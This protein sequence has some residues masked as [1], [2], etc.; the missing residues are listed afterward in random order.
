[1][2]R[3]IK[4][5]ILGG[6]M[7]AVTAVVPSL[8]TVAD[9][10]GITVYKDGDKYVKMGGRIQIQYHYED[11]DTGSPTDRSV[12]ELFFR[13]LRP[14]IEGSLHKDWKGK[15]QFDLGKSSNDNE[16]VIK[17]AYMQYTGIENVKVTVGNSHTP[18]SR[19][20]LTSSKKQQLVERTFVGDHNYGSPDRNLGIHVKGTTSDKKIGWAVSAA[21]ASIDPDDDKLDFDTPVNKSDDWNEGWLAGARLDFHPLGHLAMAQGDFKRDETKATISVAAFSWNNDDDNNT[22]TDATTGL[23]DGKGKPDVDTVTGYEISGALRTA[24]ISIDAQYNS[25]DVDLK[26]SSVTAGMYKDGSS[27]LTSLAIEGGYM[28][29]P[30]KLEVVAGYE[31]QDADNYKTEWTRSSVGANYFIKKYDIKV[32]ATYRIGEGIK[33]KKDNDLNEFFAQAQYVF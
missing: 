20:T 33:G 9:A 5:L 14:Y 17:S 12:D 26:D 4:P 27:N 32:Q 28:I 6:L 15:F 10:A 30:S 24:G 16:I 23:D 13:R 25:F 3:G 2:K 21:S 7:L 8:P 11:E 31:V 29:I 22:H 19:E 1:M 18:F